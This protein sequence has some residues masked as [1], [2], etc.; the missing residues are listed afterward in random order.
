MLVPMYL[1]QEFDVE[2]TGVKHMG[3][4]QGTNGLSEYGHNPRL[5]RKGKDE[6]YIDQASLTN[7]VHRSI[8]QEWAVLM[9]WWES[10]LDFFLTSQN[11]SVFS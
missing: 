11:A 8:S 1:R 7:G 3:I 9:L 4:V 6:V 10:F 2:T 5:S